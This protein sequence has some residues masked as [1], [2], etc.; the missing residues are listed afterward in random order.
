MF[1][2]KDHKRAPVKLGLLAARTELAELA[3]NRRTN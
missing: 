1:K 2:D 3:P